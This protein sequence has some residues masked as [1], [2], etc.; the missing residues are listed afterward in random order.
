[1]KLIRYFQILKRKLNM[2]NL[3]LQILTEQADLI[4][5]ALEA[6]IFRYGR[7]WR[8]IWF[9][10]WRRIFFW[11]KKKNGPQR[12]ADIETAIDLTFEEAVFG[13]EKEISVNKHENCDNCNGTGAKP[14]TSPKDCDKCGGTGRI[15]IQ[16]NTI[17]GSMV[18]ETSCDKCGGSGKVI[19][20][21]CNK[22][23]GKGKIRKNKK[24]KS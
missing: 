24:I 10:L 18:T 21:P 9:L 2:I 3:E 6:S 1:M 19:E 12:G 8:Y 16:K 13:A 14:G 20:N 11:W 17:L 4:R 5:Q 7:L 22:C 23:H 15:R